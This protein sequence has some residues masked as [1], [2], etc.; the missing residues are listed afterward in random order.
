MNYENENYMFFFVLFFFACEKGREK[1]R[2]RHRKIQKDTKTEIR[3]K[4]REGEER[5]KTDRMTD[6]Q[7]STHRRTDIQKK[8]QTDVIN[9]QLTN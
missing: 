6:G 3:D 9:S 8:K 5:E 7:T 1:Q 4:K 2:G